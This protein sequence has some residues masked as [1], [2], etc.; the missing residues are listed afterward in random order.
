MFS[1]WI[2][3]RFLFTF[4]LTAL[5][6]ILIGFFFVVPNIKNESENSLKT[7][8]Y[9]NTSIDF[10]IPGP[11]K[12][13]LNEI[14]NMDFIDAAF[15]YYYTETSVKA[16]GKGVTQKIIFSDCM[17][18]VEITMFNESRIVE[19]GKDNYSNPIYVDYE[20]V[21]K[22]GVGIGDVVELSS[23]EFQVAGIY[24]TNSYNNAILAPL[25]GEQKSL[26]E[27][28][29]SGY[30]GA[31][32]KVSDYA[33]ADSYLKKYKPLGRLKDKSSFD[34][35]EEYN[36]HYK[37]WESANYYNEVT[38]FKGKLESLNLTP[39]TNTWLIIGMY[40]VVSILMNII[41]FIRK[42]EKKYFREKKSKKHI[43][44]YYFLTFVEE[45]LVSVGCCFVLI[46][47]TVKSNGILLTANAKQ[48]Y[49]VIVV[50]F[51]AVAVFNYVLNALLLK[52]VANE[53]K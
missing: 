45:V 17:D 36:I 4:V 43:C 26:I 23:I 27:S 21:K 49:F 2:K 52:T 53:N 9:E 12:E 44:M 39:I 11:T 8:V 6:A 13:Q 5:I 40:A 51:V 14:Q 20:F 47:L 10:D 33:K 29:N 7:S 37:A 31:F 18:K 46:T 35:E 42:S 24:E 1:Y 32:L 30:S 25:V 16:K 50:G 48:G 41:L 34:S 28:K 22:T 19:Q 38:S 15:G 3:N